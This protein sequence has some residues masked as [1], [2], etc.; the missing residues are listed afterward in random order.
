MRKLLSTIVLVAVAIVAMAQ[1]STRKSYHHEKTFEGH[2]NRA[3]IRHEGD[4]IYIDELY[5]FN[6]SSSI[7]TTTTKYLSN[8]SVKLLYEYINKNI[9]FELRNLDTVIL[10]RFVVNHDSTIG[11]IHFTQIK[12][13]TYQE[14]RY[15][16]G[17]SY[18]STSSI[19]I[20]SDIL[21]QEAKYP[22]L[23]SVIKNIPKNLIPSVVVGLLHKENQTSERKKLLSEER[24]V[25]YEIP[26][27]LLDTLN[28][29]SIIVPY[30]KGLFLPDRPFFKN[31]KNKFDTKVIN[32]IDLNYDG[33]LVPFAR[34]EMKFII[35]KKGKAKDITIVRGDN[36]R[37]SN[38]IKNVIKNSK[39]QP[40]KYRNIPLDCE[41][42]YTIEIKQRRIFN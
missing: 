42:I 22:K 37:M 8:D 26:I 34:F 21:K 27:V 10:C 11:D 16:D 28:L 12:E 7:R 9:S 41:F 38:I 39:W 18:K 20:P 13:Y 6:D 32:A 23:T 40:G 30:N 31:G 3:L 2:P 4:V 24:K 1:G 35:T 29:D 19:E 25:I 15:L 5:V 14:D 33:P 36:K 17:K